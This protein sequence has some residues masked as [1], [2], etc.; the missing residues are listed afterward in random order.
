[1]EGQ[2]ET[3]TGRQDL[4]F[5]LQ[6]MGHFHHRNSIPGI[7]TGGCLKGY[8]EYAMTGNFAFEE[9]TQELMIFTPERGLTFQAPI[10]VQDKEDEGW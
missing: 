8:D 1:V 10:H 6:I 2:A 5:D 3:Y 7:V 9:A 4:R